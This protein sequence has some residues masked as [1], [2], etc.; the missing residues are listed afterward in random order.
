ML[1][2]AA[3]LGAC[4]SDEPAAPTTSGRDGG[5]DHGSEL[6]SSMEPPTFSVEDVAALGPGPRV[7]D[8]W[9]G[10]L[11]LNVCGR[12]LE[13]PTAATPASGGFST[14][15]NGTFEL[16]PGQ[17]ADA[18][19]S[20]TVGDLAELVG[21]EVSTGELRL[22]SGTQ[23]TSIDLGPAGTD[24]SDVDVAGAV[25]RTGDACGESARGEVQLWVYDRAAV[26]SGDVVRV[27]TDPQDVP[28]VEDGMALV[29]AF[30][31]ESSLPTL[32]PS[33]LIDPE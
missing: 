3:A 10:L 11:G 22:P 18:G 29:I 25:L 30:S 9:K 5:H 2:L 28:I 26:D 15:G 16:A 4:S 8:R 32:P 31:P 17:E 6:G 23:P 27:V 20:A 24:D 13:P 33:A 1:A 21:I 7:G 14:A 12:F 19:H